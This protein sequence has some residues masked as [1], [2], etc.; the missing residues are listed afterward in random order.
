MGVEV[1]VHR[2][3]GYALAELR[4]INHLLAGVRRAF[5]AL[6]PCSVSSLR[7]PVERHRE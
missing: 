3:T 6:L 4:W 1:E 5:L 2:L 7:R